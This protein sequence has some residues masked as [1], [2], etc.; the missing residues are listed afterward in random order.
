MF[1]L[2]NDEPQKEA[3]GSQA[4]EAD[5][6][7]NLKRFDSDQVTPNIGA[8]FDFKYFF[9]YFL[10]LVFLVSIWSGMRYFSY[11]QFYNTVAFVS[12]TSEKGGNLIVDHIVKGAKIF[13]S[14]S[15]RS[16]GGEKEIVFSRWKTF[17]V[18]KHSFFVAQKTILANGAYL[19]GQDLYL[20]AGD[21]TLSVKMKIHASFAFLKKETGFL[22]AE[23]GDGYT[24]LANWTTTFSSQF[25]G[26]YVALKNRLFV[27]TPSSKTDIS[28]NLSLK[29]EKNDEKEILSNESQE[30]KTDHLVREVIVAKVNPVKVVSGEVKNISN[31]LFSG[32]KQGAGIFTDNI[33][34]LSETV[35]QVAV[36][37]FVDTNKT[38]TETVKQTDQ[39]LVIN[40]ENFVSKIKILTEKDSDSKLSS[41]S[42]EI[43]LDKKI[44]N[45]VSNNKTDKDLLV[46]KSSTGDYQPPRILSLIEW[47]TIP[48][49]NSISVSVYF[50]RAY[51]VQAVLRDTFDFAIRL[52]N[53]LFGDVYLAW[54]N[55]INQMLA[56]RDS[57]DLSSNNT[58]EQLKK[59]IL[60]E[61]QSEGLGN[62]SIQ[63]SASTSLFSDSG[64]VLVK[65]SG[66]TTIDL[67][68]LKK[69]Q[70]SFSDRV[71]VNFNEDGKTG[72]IQP[73]FRDRV[74]EK[75]IFIL[76]PIKK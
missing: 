27:Q 18:E 4:V 29:N 47:L 46:L 35:K 32:V 57:V 13:A 71:L 23:I 33:L 8:P 75:Y 9:S 6:V 60:A 30:K 45:K 61:I 1:L 55:F 51:P 54:S 64:V 21:I 74:G 41:S 65:P 15:V 37:A 34:F 69:L 38:I 36:G 7:Y 52:P 42:G 17:F 56:S 68:S 48:S 62:V 70:D 3:E 25:K 28:K 67:A 10:V 12:S 66:S 22:L 16:I 2:E 73:V 40:R 59:E 20:T 72:V 43:S 53:N 76:T 39:Q 14:S 19:L 31:D 11:R 63:D 24:Q 26:R 50:E 49:F 5:L 44:S 58:R